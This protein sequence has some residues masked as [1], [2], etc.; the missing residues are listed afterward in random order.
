MRMNVILID[1]LSK[2]PMLVMPNNYKS[3]LKMVAN[4]LFTITNELN[5]QFCNL[6]FKHL[7]DL[8]Q[9]YGIAKL[10]VFD[11]PISHF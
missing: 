11:L 6:N 5:A 10:H 8:I 1:R 3:G 4:C 9:F 7:H 2:L